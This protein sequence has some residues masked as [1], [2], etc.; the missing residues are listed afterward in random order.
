MQKLCRFGLAMVLTLALALAPVRAG[1]GKENPAAE[2]SASDESAELSALELEIGELRDLLAG[3]SRQMEEQS[4]LLQQ[5]QQ[6]INLLT[7]RLQAM[8]AGRNTPA[9]PA[10]AGLAVAASADAAAMPARGPPAAPDAPPRRIDERIAR[11]GPF[12]FSGD[13]RL[14]DEPFF[15]GPSTQ[16]LVR[17]RGRLRA[18]V[19]INARLNDEISG[20]LTLASGHLEDAISTNQ[21][22]DAFYSRK[23]IQLDRA[24]INYNP[25]Q[26]RPL[27]L[28]AGKF[29]VPWY[30]TELTWDNDVN[31]EGAAQTLNF[32]L[33]NTPVLKRIAVV[34]FELPFAQTTGVNFNFRPGDTNRSIRQSAVYGG[35][36]QTE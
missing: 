29:A 31:V 2:R 15:G 32:A 20:G 33:A 35:Q 17:H 24:F 5:Q 30:R 6:A 10:A 8:T 28:T 3:Q 27:T 22:L 7:Q 12:T 18:R 25:R 14:R 13:L 4:R 9:S 19:N 1:D 23:P 34:G 26:L 11:I 21:D 16:A 36:L